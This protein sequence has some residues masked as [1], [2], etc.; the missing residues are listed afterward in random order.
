MRG[1]ACIIFKGSRVISCALP[2]ELANAYFS[3]SCIL[4]M[5][6]TNA[7][8]KIAR[9]PKKLVNLRELILSNTERGAMIRNKKAVMQMARDVLISLDITFLRGVSSTIGV[10]RSPTATM[11]ATNVPKHRTNILNSTRN[12]KRCPKQTTE[13]SSKL[14]RPVYRLEST[15]NWILNMVDAT[16]RSSNIVPNTTPLSANAD[17]MERA[18]A[19]KVALHKLK[20]DPL[21]DPERIY[22]EISSFFI[23]KR[24]VGGGEGLLSAS[25][26]RCTLN[27]LLA[28]TVISCRER[29]GVL[30]S[31]CRLGLYPIKSTVAWE[32]RRVG[33]S[34]W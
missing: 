28:S 15:S 26:D 3:K 33:V 12:P 17:G 27:W 23:V 34:T 14:I 5:A 11:Y 24:G 8:K 31:G 10:M 19:P 1:T 2:Q 32:E 22:L 21:M 4:V 6:H 25:F 29:D 9:T 18:P 20:T 30:Y 13:I 7:R 16:P